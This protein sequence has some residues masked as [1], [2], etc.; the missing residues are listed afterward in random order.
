MRALLCKELGEPLIHPAAR[1]Q[2]EEPH[3][4]YEKRRTYR[5][6]KVAPAV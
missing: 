5:I 3:L 4:P 1:R 6:G 2:L